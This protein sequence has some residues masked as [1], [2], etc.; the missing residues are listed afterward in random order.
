MKKFLLLVAAVLSFPAT[1]NAQVAIS[2]ERF[3]RLVDIAPTVCRA[4]REQGGSMADNITSLVYLQTTSERL[5]MLAMCK[6]YLHGIL[7][8]VKGNV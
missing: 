7:D 5:L 3:Q 1:A 4:A 6:T 8:S 2:P